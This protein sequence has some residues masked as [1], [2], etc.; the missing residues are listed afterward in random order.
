MHINMF[1][2]LGL[3]S[4]FWF[5]LC[6]CSYRNIIDPSQA[7]INIAGNGIYTLHKH[8]LNQAYVN[9][10]VYNV[11]KIA[12]KDGTLKRIYTGGQ[13]GVDLA[14]A[15]AGYALGIPTEVTLPKGFKQRF[16]DGI[17]V[18]GTEDSI[19]EQIYNGVKQLPI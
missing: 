18:D 12:L 3:A 10:L 16:A 5:R 15:V 19:R 4:R 6:Q 1:D 14:G 13:T 2:N 7:T 11:L 17:D 8:G 9:E